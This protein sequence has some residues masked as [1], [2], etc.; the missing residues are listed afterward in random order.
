VARIG[1][2]PLGPAQGDIMSAIRVLLVDDSPDFLD[3]A[4]QF[5]HGQPGLEVVGRVLSAVEALELIPRLRP[6]L[7][8]LDLN[9]PHT[10]GLAAARQIKAR[11]DAPRVVLL[12]L[13]DSSIF[14]L[15]AQAVGVDGFV[16]K[17]ELGQELLPLID[18]LFA[19]RHSP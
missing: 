16:G 13:H 19:S 1:S 9:M 8:L 18:T 7:V 11:A 4:A 15:A 3:A 14:R 12:S 17:T 2:L 5:L 10:D 6:H